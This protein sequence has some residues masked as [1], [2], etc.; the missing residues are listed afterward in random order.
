MHALAVPVVDDVLREQRIA[1]TLQIWNASKES[2]QQIVDAQT[3]KI[4]ALQS[5]VPLIDTATHEQGLPPEMVSVRSRIKLMKTTR[6]NAC[7][8]E[9]S[10]MTSLDIADSISRTLLITGPPPRR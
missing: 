3:P 7:L 1:L 8:D 6:D 4:T 9:I 10:S 2:L 5:L